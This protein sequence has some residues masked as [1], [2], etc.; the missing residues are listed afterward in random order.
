MY[1]ILDGERVRE[2]REEEGMSRRDL[3]ATA[4]ISPTTLRRVE[5]NRGPVSLTSARKVG[6]ALDVNPR[7]F[8]RAVSRRPA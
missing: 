8:G 5:D 1:V 7:V 4:G 3:A 6:R 2:L